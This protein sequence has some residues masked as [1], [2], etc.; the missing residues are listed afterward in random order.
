[1]EEPKHINP[2]MVAAM[3]NSMGI[4]F[5]FLLAIYEYL[6]QYAN[7]K[8][9]KLTDRSIIRAIVE[10]MSFYFFNFLLFLIPATCYA[11]FKILGN[12]REYVVAAKY[13]SSG[14]NGTIHPSETIDM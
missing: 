10:S 12:N 14:N 7:K 3:L 1:M 5:L 2:A 9:F 4:V 13:S 11:C 6:R 8:L